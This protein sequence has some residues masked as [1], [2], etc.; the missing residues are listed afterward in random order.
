MAEPKKQ[1]KKR[2][3]TEE[4]LTRIVELEKK[5]ESLQRGLGQSMRYHMTGGPR[6]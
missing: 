2:V 4:L 5:I 1:K 3:T 6:F